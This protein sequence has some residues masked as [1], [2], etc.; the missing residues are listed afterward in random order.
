MSERK[1]LYDFYFSE[2]TAK[3]EDEKSFKPVYVLFKGEFYRYTETI[4]EGRIPTREEKDNVLIC[5]TTTD[6]IRIYNKE[7]TCPFCQEKLTPV[8]TKG[9]VTPGRFECYNYEN[10]TYYKMSLAK[11]TVRNNRTAIEL[12]EEIL[13]VIG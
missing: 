2:E 9:G 1:E 10:C 8:T 4:K 6:K 5:T 3:R 13:I 12:H 7:L 11:Y